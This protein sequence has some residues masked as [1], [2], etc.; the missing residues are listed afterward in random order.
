MGARGHEP[1]V[2]LARAQLAHLLG[3][4]GRYLSALSEAHRL[5]TEMGAP[6]RAAR[7]AKKLG[8]PW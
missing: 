2:L 3:D 7:V 5:L 1:D 4:E 8:L 6:I